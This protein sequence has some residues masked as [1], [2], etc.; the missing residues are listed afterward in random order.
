MASG[1][2]SLQS[3]YSGV[4]GLR[5]K[6]MDEGKV[7]LNPS[8]DTLKASFAGEKA[9]QEALCTPSSWTRVILFVV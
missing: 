2:C 8:R 4:L 6:N 9:G 7:R 3:G 1:Y 5:L